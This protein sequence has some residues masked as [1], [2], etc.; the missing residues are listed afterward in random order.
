M[1]DGLGR[2]EVVRIALHTLESVRYEDFIAAFT[3]AYPKNV[4]H[5]RRSET[6]DIIDLL[7]PRGAAHAWAQCVADHLRQ[8]GMNAVVAPEWTD[9]LRGV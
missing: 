3:F 2:T 4:I 6:C 5:H 9:A 7:P 8:L 1:A